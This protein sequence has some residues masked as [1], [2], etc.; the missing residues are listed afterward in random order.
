MSGD[1]FGC[2]TGIG[3]S[4]TGI[5]WAEAK[6]AAVSYNTQNSPYGKSIAWP[7]MSIV[8]ELRNRWS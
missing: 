8:L 7:E 5:Y 1:G 3:S 2:H 4:S 6:G